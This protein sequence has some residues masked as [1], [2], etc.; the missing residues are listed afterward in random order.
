MNVIRFKSFRGE[1]ANYAVLDHFKKLLS[2]QG[3]SLVK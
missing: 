3:F 2:P 1:G